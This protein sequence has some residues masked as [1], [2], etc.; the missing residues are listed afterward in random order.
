VARRGGSAYSRAHRRRLHQLKELP[1]LRSDLERFVLHC[2]PQGFAPNTVH[3]YAQVLKASSTQSREQEGD[4]RVTVST[5][6]IQYD[7]APERYSGKGVV[8][9]SF[10]EGQYS[11]Y[12]DLEPDGP[13]TPLEECPRSTSAREVVSWGRQRTPRVLIRPEADPGQY[14]WAGAE[15]PTAPYAELPTWR[16]E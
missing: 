11:G 14:Y 8:Y 13:P 1:G 16:E 12:W 10:D 2:R 9:L 5:M 7:P 6:G 3:G 15:T 4:R